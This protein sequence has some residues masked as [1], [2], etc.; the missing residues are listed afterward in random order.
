VTFEELRGGLEAA[1]GIEVEI[2]CGNGHFLADYAARN[3]A[4]L[5]I[6]IELKKKRCLKAEEKARKHKL[7]N[8][9][10]V[11][12]KAECY[13]REIPSRAV[14][15]FHIYFPDPWPKSRHRKRRLLSRD[16][17]HVLF[18][19]LRAGGRIFFSTDFFD[20]YVQAKVLFLLHG[21]FS[22]VPEVMPEESFTS[23]YGMKS[24]KARRDIHLITA[25]KTGNAWS[26]DHPGQEQEE[27][28]YI[29]DDV[30]DDE[31]EGDKLEESGRL[32]AIP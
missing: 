4:T 29:D 23:I 25:V 20:Y 26:T 12:A 27:G 13:I 8:V 16:T 7:G 3:P 31:H 2:G 5:L 30:Q 32:A 11:Q 17:I 9:V 14:D 22:L 10:I 18:G 24:A 21:G 6:G 28:R 19:R 15:A 1:G